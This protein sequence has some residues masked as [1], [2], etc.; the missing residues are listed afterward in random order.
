MKK[1]IVLVFLTLQALPLQ[2]HEGHDKAFANKDAMVAT[3]QKV[4]IAPEGQAAIGL[5][6]S[7]VSFF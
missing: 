1:A 6:T 2:A 7:R 5:K 4:H 3:N